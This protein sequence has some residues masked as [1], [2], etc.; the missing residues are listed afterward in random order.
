M[1]SIAYCKSRL[2]GSVVLVLA[3]C[4]AAGGGL[5]TEQPAPSL[6]TLARAV[7]V[8]PDPVRAD[9][10]W[11]VISEMSSVYAEAAAKARSE[12]GRVSD[13][14]TLRTWA[15]AVQAFADSLAKTADEMGAESSVAVR[16][17]A[18]RQ[19]HLYVDGT[20]VIVSSPDGNAQAGFEQRILSRF[21]SLH[22][23]DRMVPPADPAELPP[24]VT[25]APANWEF[26]ERAGPI[27]MSG[28]G[29]EFQFRDATGLPEKRVLCQQA[30]IEL[31]S[32]VRRVAAE[33]ARGTWIDW[34]VMAIEPLLGETSHLVVLNGQGDE[35]R[36]SL[37][38][39]GD[40]PDLF[41]VVKPWLAA[42][43]SG[44]DYNLV[45]LNAGRL[46]GF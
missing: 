34:N 3:G 23:C 16:I 37:P 44:N 33:K 26:S 19:V 22:R 39:L 43:V 42:R 30:I 36:Q 24:V 20:P 9:F 25:N 31:E 18:D 7:A 4:M 10:A 8:E 5:A 38:V 13:S 46:F 40:R 27:C 32:L 1:N 14:R 35:V 21:C 6:E 28:N 41:R 12:T 17:G 11:L 45:V 15:N 2:A 29:L